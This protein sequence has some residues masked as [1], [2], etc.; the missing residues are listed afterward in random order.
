[1]VSS[2]YYNSMGYSEVRIFTSVAVARL[3][4]LEFIVTIWLHK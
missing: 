4:C 1:M 2:G 3:V